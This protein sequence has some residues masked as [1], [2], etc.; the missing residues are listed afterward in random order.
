MS[1]FLKIGHRGAKGYVTENTLE[2]IVKAIDL[3][4][5]GVEIDVHVCKTGELVVF[6]DFIL[7][8]ITNGVGAIANLTLKDIKKLKVD[9]QFKI[10]TLIEVLDLIDNTIVI[11]IELKGEG[12]AIATDHIV[13]DYIDNKGWALDNIIVSSFKHSVLLELYNINPDIPLGVLTEDNFS[14]ALAFANVIK[15][16]AIHPKFSLL[17]K[18]NVAQ[19]QALGYKIN[20]WTVNTK[21][22]IKQAISYQVD[23]IISDFPD[24]L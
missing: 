12:T 10:P 16:K 1:K 15:A 2:S 18:L 20:T 7:D 22:D 3:G 6:H 21:Q 13:K 14:E 23:A 9:N 5:D 4:V 11:N 8:R 24:R 17:T 19:A